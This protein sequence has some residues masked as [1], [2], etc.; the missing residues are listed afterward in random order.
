[1]RKCPMKR[2]KAQSKANAKISFLNEM[3]M[4]NTRA[5]EEG[6]IKK[7]WTKFDIQTIKPLT[8][9]QEEMFHAFFNGDN[10]CAHGS[11]GTGKTFIGLYL[12]FLEVL[13][14]RFEPDHIIIVRS[15]VPTRDLGHLPGTLE[16]KASVDERPYIDICE[17]LFGHT[18]TYEQMKNAGLIKFM[19]TSYIR[20]LTWNN[21]VV[22]V[23]E[24]QN[25]NWHEIDSVMTRIGINTRIVALGDV[26]QSDLSMS[27][28][29][30]SGVIP[31]LDVIKDM[32]SFEHIRFGREDI[33]RSE[34]V[35]SW[36]IASEN[37]NVA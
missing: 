18:T 7:K 8:P 11:A 1:M 20:G 32:D 28:K 15:I 13:D 24:I 36:I 31:F 9:A 30:K 4:N 29:D 25:L 19:S 17:D 10:I 12:A 37:R 21:A 5:M 16:E 22:I 34:F 6:P 23:D 33:V 14:K 35:K 26:T 2:R 27:G 3:N